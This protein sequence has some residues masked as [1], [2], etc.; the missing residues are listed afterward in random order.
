MK[1]IKVGII[2]LGVGEKH[3]EGY[4][5]HPQCEVA[6]LCDFDKQKIMQM[7]QKYPN[8]KI[9]NDANEVIDAKDVDIISIASYDNYHYEQA[10]RA[11]QNNKHVFIEKPVC[12]YE[13][14]AIDLKK[15]LDKKRNIHLS[16][17]LILR[18]CPRFIFLKKMI[19][20]DEMGSLY[21]IEGDYN[22]GRLSKIT[23]GWRSKID[24]YSVVYGG[25]VHIVDLLMWFA[26]SRIK[27]VCAYS[28][29]IVSKNTGFRYDDMVTSIFNFEN[30]IIGKLGV[31]FGCVFP[32]FHNISVYGTKAT[33]INGLDN[34][35]LFEK[36][37]NRDYRK[38]DEAYPG[39]QKGDLIYNFIDSILN[40]AVQIV[41]SKDV[42]DV[43][44][45]CFAI[46][47]AKK[48]NCAVKVKY[49]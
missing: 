2:G 49:L 38:I 45:V 47:K 31:N 34:G 17:N 27:E 3:I 10:A 33:F 42:F 25:G 30:G 44:S 16:S 24:F 22:Y 21:C 23:E 39:V 19:D 12:I 4:N 48:K 18:M 20:N 8:L 11:I 28:N 37:E 13:K 5:S 14:E 36:R 15:T 32:H 9:A 6:V 46:E 29:K 7:K 43:M 40:D 35:M 1:K 41:T 26:G